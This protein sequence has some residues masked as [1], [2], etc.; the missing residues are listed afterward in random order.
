MDEYFE[1]MKRTLA[2]QIN[3]H[4]GWKKLSIRYSSPE[5]VVL[6]IDEIDL[7]MRPYFV[8][9]NPDEF[10]STD[11]VGAD[12]DDEYVMIVRYWSEDRSVRYGDAYIEGQKIRMTAEYKKGESDRWKY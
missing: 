9:K 11:I 2:W 5:S 12:V 3:W 6:A 4:Q 10:I 8:P 1:H 7:D